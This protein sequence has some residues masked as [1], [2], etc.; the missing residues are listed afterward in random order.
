M[1]QTAI[2]CLL[3]THISWVQCFICTV[4]SL[5]ACQEVMGAQCWGEAGAQVRGAA[6]LLP[7][8][9]KTVSRNSF[10]GAFDQS[11]QFS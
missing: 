11:N 1:G 3:G 5:Q 10:S 8:N 6:F 4:A 7:F 9:G 2:L